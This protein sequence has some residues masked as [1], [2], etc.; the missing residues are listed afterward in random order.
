MPPEPPPLPVLA[1]FHTAA[2]VAEV[3]FDRPLTP[4][5]LD[6]TNWW[7]RRFN[8]QWTP[9]AGQAG[10]PPN[11]ATTTGW[12]LGPFFP[13][14]DAIWYDPPPFNVR[15]VTGT[16]APGIHGFPLTVLP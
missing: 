7:L 13:G 3:D 15:G 16:P 11:R 10:V 5:A 4:A 14:V 8:Q 1:R 12:T 6:P 9:L 2:G